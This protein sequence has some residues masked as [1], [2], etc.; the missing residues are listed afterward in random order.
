MVPDTTIGE[1]WMTGIFNCPPVVLPDF[2][3]NI[4]RALADVP[5]AHLPHYTIREFEAQEKLRVSIRVLVNDDDE[6]R[7]ATFACIDELCS[8]LGVGGEI[9]TDPAK[10]AW[11]AK[12]ENPDWNLDRCEALHHL[13]KVAVQLLKEGLPGPRLGGWTNSRRCYAHLFI[14]MMGL[15]EGFVEIAEEHDLGN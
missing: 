9:Y 10:A 1:N 12:G 5:G 14:N 2:L 8:D 15:R 3:D 7:K 11:L 4:F 6:V 13:S